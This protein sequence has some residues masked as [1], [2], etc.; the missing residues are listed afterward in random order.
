MST[1]DE[2]TLNIGA[3]ST[4]T[5]VPVETIRTW[6]RRYGFPSSRRNEAGHR[7]Y[8][9]ETIEQMRLITAVLAVGYRPSQLQGRTC[10]ELE[11]LL[12]RSAPEAPVSE[13]PA[14]PLGDDNEGWL[15]RWLQAVGQLD[16]E[17]LEGLMRMGWSRLNALDFVEERVGP[18]L[19]ALGEAW[20]SGRLSVLHEHFASE[21]VRDFLVAAWRPL[22]DLARGH[23][24]VLATL[25]GE[26]H[27][28]GLHMA[29]LI[30]AVANQRVIFLGTDAP[31][32]DIAGAARQAEAR[33]VALSMSQYADPE[34]SR[35]YLERLR[36]LVEPTIDIIVGGTG[37][38]D[39]IRGVH[40]LQGFRAYYDFF[41]AW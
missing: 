34:S 8:D 12:A 11:E 31:A 5:G 23:T 1:E 26:R 24:V 27:C 2:A 29:A 16:R 7:I 38:P 10:Q 15:E 3:L 37:A 18:F 19:V 39:D 4:A 22:S 28:L 20:A 6:E 21:C 9:L 36:G 41:R 32:E 33:G 13:A 17:R 35:A 30:A 14:A 25:S 40:R